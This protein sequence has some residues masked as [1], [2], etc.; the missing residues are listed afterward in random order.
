[1]NS[2]ISILIIFSILSSSINEIE[3]S[4]YHGDL[5]KLKKFFPD[6]R[7]IFVFLPKPFSLTGYLSKDQTIYTFDWIFKDYKTVSIRVR[8]GNTIKEKK[9]F[10]ILKTE[11]NFFNRTSRK[12]YMSV[13][14]ISLKK[15]QN[16]WK[17]IEIK[18]KEF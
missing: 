7:E 18:S 3:N 2:V 1:M 15:I 14:L 10:V 16:N 13:I 8:G 9:D 4:F 12:N 11:W 6:D 5:A 17:I